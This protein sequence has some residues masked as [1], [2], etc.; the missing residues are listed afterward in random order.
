MAKFMQHHA[1]E[2][3]QNKDDAV[4]RFNRPAAR[5]L[6]RSDPSQQEKKRHVK[7]NGGATD[8]E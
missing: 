3:E 2:Q 4:N 6:D 7:A 8:I 5:P 1:D